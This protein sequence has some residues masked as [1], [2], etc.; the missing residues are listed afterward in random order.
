[1]WVAASKR[2]GACMINIFCMSMWPRLPI[3]II[4]RRPLGLE[5]SD[6]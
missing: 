5:D 4:T 6:A 2:A 3:Y 1:M